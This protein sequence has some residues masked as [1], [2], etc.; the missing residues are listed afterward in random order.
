LIP[1]DPHPNSWMRPGKTES[2]YKRFLRKSGVI[3]RNAPVSTN[4]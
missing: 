3:P 2:D 1:H 4:M